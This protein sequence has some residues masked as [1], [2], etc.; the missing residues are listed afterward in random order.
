MLADLLSIAGEKK[1]SWP[2]SQL[3]SM[4]RHQ[5][6]APLSFVPDALRDT[7]GK[8][9]IVTLVNSIAVLIYVVLVRH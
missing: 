8:V 7:L 3:E 2:A 9:A 1:V 4:W 6:N 5:L